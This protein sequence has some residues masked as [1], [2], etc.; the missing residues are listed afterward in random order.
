MAG[1]SMGSSSA[2]PGAW[3]RWPAHRTFPIFYH[4]L[5]VLGHLNHAVYFPFMETLRCD[6]YLASTGSLDPSKLDIILAEAT[7]KYLAPAHYGMEL[8]GEVA[9]AKPLGRTSFAL[10]Y[11][12]RDPSGGPTVYARGRTVVVCYDYATNRKKEIA[13]ELRARLERDAIDPTSEGWA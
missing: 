3:G 9:P 10:L 1:P 11:R 13:P 4:H 7:C 12:F 2:G 5:D 8:L 6:Y